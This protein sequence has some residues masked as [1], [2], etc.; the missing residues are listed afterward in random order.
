M[1]AMT[2][3][4]TFALFFVRLPKE[5]LAKPP[6]LGFAIDIDTEKFNY[7]DIKYFASIHMFRALNLASKEQSTGQT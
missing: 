7:R 3:F 1:I 5:C 2:Q 6:E 4:A